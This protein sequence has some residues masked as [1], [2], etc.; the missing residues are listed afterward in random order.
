MI[1]HVLPELMKGF[2]QPIIKKATIAEHGN[3]TE[4]FEYLRDYMEGI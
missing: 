3:L 1:E 4:K 2:D